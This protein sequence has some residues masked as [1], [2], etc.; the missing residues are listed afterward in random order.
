M[1]YEDYN[2]YKNT[3]LRFRL[4]GYDFVFLGYEAMKTVV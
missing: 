2:L 3:L 1:Y 4:L